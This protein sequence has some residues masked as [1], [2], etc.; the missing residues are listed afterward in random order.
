MRSPSRRW[1]GCPGIYIGGTASVSER[2]S[3]L[4]VGTGSSLPMCPEFKPTGA[5]ET[6]EDP[7]A[8]TKSKASSKVLW[9]QPVRF[10]GLN[11]VGWAPECRRVPLTSPGFP[12]SLTPYTS[13]YGEGP[14]GLPRGP[15][16]YD[17]CVRSQK[18]T[19]PNPRTNQVFGCD[20]NR[21]KIIQGDGETTACG[22]SIPGSLPESPDQCQTGGLCDW[23]THWAFPCNRD[24][25]R[26]RS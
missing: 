6:E 7:I 22:A 25:C 10:L 21:S 23:V 13:L 11:I 24:E 2:G 1:K 19:R 12:F 16:A 4:P 5:A 26:N 9:I 17:L 20:T 8:G 15:P 18:A 14:I 3:S